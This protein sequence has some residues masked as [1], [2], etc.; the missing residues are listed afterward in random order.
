MAM[1]YNLYSESDL[2][3]D[4]IKCKYFTFKGRLNREAFLIRCSVLY[5]L[6]LIL[7]ALFVSGVL[8]VNISA[9]ESDT[10][11][12]M[13]SHILSSAI[14]LFLLS[15]ATVFFMI[16]IISGL[17]LAIRRLHDLNLSSSWFL[18]W[19]ALFFSPLAPMFG[20]LAKAA[21]F[22]LAII[23]FISLFCLKGTKGVNKYGSNPLDEQHN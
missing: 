8:I 19:L 7:G 23:T 9:F 10:L 20:F 13:L 21:L 4:G 18:V 15:T 5:V 6:G 11:A 2:S 17:T 12:G 16:L 14:G 1:N 3:R 22:S